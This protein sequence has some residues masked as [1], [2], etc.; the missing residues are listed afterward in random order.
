M[1]KFIL[2]IV[3][4]CF[5]QAGYAFKEINLSKPNDRS[6]L[7]KNTIEQLDYLIAYN[8]DKTKGLKKDDRWFIYIAGGTLDSMIYYKNLT[9][10]GTVRTEYLK[11]LN[12]SLI[13]LNSHSSTAVYVAFTDYKNEIL[14]PVFPDD[15]T[16]LLE[17]EA[18]IKK[19]INNVDDLNVNNING[20]NNELE[21][22][23][24]QL[25]TFSKGFQKIIEEVYEGSEIKNINKPNILMPFSNYSIRQVIKSGTSDYKKKKI[26][27]YTLYTP[28]L[29]E[30]IVKGQ[31]KKIYNEMAISSYGSSSSEQVIDRV[32]RT[33]S[34][35]YHGKRPPYKECEELL[36]EYQNKP[37]MTEFPEFREHVERNPCIL[38]NIIPWGE[39]IEK[40][41]WMTMTETLIVIPLYAAMAIP[42]ASVAGAAALR[43]IGKDKARDISIAVAANVVIQTSMNYYFGGKEITSITDN[44][45]RWTKALQAVNKIEVSKEIVDAVVNLNTR[46][47]IIIA[48]LE[49]G[50]DIEGV[51]WESFDVSNAKITV[52]FKGCVANV[53][54]YVFIDG[55]TEKALGYIFK[56]LSTL[57][58]NDPKEFVR[59]WRELLD[60]FGPT[61]KQDFKN[62][63]KD[64]KQDIFT[65]FG[66]SKNVDEKIAKYIKSMFEVEENL[67]EAIEDYV[68]T[69]NNQATGNIE[70]TIKDIAIETEVQ[71]KNPSIASGTKKVTRQG[72]NITIEV[73]TKSGKNIGIKVPL[74][75]EIEQSGKK[76]YRIVFENNNKS[77]NDISSSLTGNRKAVVEA[78]N[79]GNISSV[80]TKG[81]NA[82]KHLELQQNQSID[83]I[84]IDIRTV[85]AN[86]NVLSKSVLDG[87][88]TAFG[89]MAKRLKEF[90]KLQ[91]KVLVLPN[92][93]KDFL[94]DFTHAS[95]EVID[96]FGADPDLVDVWVKMKKEG[97]LP[98]LRTNPKVLRKTKNFDC[99]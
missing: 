71:I 83:I 68:K 17:K 46:Q 9:A 79:N 89:N 40:S 10:K 95:N 50:V 84:D 74:L 92:K 8:K 77:L 62:G 18:Y 33:I 22:S 3:L 7:I 73:T 51:N 38:K 69:A 4:I 31:F 6:V 94:D 41:E 28:K 5:F 1:N 36:K 14:T 11:Y 30:K 87:A 32:I 63:I 81:G 59:A 21:K 48:C 13:S 12:D 72:A 60:D 23:L 70:N 78:I 53:L 19:L 20:T 27:S 47:K 86:G 29:K 82:N 85:D 43:E 91:D 34:I 88:D 61:V 99:K 54:K 76:I 16:S 37:I 55:P 64:Y 90:S 65:A 35:Y 96:A 80:V 42:V 39:D 93:G 26:H 98:N 67:G 44:Q 15:A 25:T 66:L 97:I 49:K 24:K 52:D 58:K 2:Q 57:I 75:E 56:R 45:Q